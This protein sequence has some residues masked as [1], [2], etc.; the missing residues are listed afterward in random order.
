MVFAADHQ[1][2]WQYAQ[3]PIEDAH[4][5][6]QLEHLYILTL[7]EGFGKGDDRDVVCA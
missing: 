5:Y 7:Q 6:V 4:I 2:T 1:S 3:R